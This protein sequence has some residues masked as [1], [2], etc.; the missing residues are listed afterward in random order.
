MKINE[1]NE[2]NK[3]T[4]KENIE[5]FIRLARTK[6]N[7]PDSQIFQNA[8]L[9]EG[10]DMDKVLLSFS[11]FLLFHFPSFLIRILSYQV[12]ET[13]TEIQTKLDNGEYPNAGTGLKRGFDYFT[14]HKHFHYV[15][16]IINFFNLP[17]FSSLSSLS[18]TSI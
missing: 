13:I 5:N 16:L 2:T 14:I 12:V 8:D 15:K 17:W 11:F 1:I 6:L 9:F 7:L 3:F 10:R 18:L 4:L